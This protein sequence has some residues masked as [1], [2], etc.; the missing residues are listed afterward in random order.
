MVVRIAT[1]N[2]DSDDIAKCVIMDGKDQ[3]PSGTQ[4]EGFRE[5]Y[6]I[7]LRRRILLSGEPKMDHRFHARL[8]GFQYIVAIGFQTVVELSKC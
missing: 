2:E 4:R 3:C 7:T 1:S 5:T 8:Y 6:I